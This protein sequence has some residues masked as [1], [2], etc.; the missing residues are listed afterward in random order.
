M[1]WVAVIVA[2]SLVAGCGGGTP[3]PARQTETEA[4]VIELPPPTTS[5][6]MSIEEAL[7]SRRSV[8]EFT[9]EPLTM[10]ELSQLL[11][12]AQGV[13][14]KGG[15]RTSPS[16]GALYPLEIYV[17]DRT[18][19]HHYLPELHVLERIGD[20]DLRPALEGAA[21][22]QTAV[23]ESAAVFIVAAV[24]SRT[25]AKYGARAD[26]Y[27]KLEAG[28]AAQNLLLQAVA[29]ELGA[30]PI[31]AFG[32]QEIQRLLELSEDTEPVYLV[33]VGHPATRP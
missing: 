14:S 20:D 13:T 21:L 32:D 26:R 24:P 15:K 1:R 30:V 5:G 28:H 10:A 9:P 6:T 17:A 31:G 11:W 7:A 23:G 25:E 33:G 27:V 2:L 29:L 3:E 12:A 22:G 19:S 4:E 8:R 16:A 18:G